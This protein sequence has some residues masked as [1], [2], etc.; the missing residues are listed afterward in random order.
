MSDTR[1]A[2]GHLLGNRHLLPLRVYYEDT[3][4]GGIVYHGNFVRFFERGRSEMLRALGIDHAAAW[5]DPDPGA[6]VGFAVRHMEIDYLA[7]A[8][9]DDA[10]TVHSEVVKVAA[11]YVDARQWIARDGTTIARARFRVALVDERGRPRRMPADWRRKLATV[12]VRDD[13]GSG[14]AEMTADAGSD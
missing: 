5:R 8:L 13:D 7:P 6:R 4:A 3:D 12:A 1:P 10:L 11:A 14:I 9:L 2:G